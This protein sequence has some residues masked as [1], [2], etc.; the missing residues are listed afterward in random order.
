MSI[1]SKIESGYV[2]FIEKYQQA[3]LFAMGIYFIFKGLIE[4]GPGVQL[5]Q[6]RF[7]LGGG[8][9]AEA[10]YS[11]VAILMGIYLI[12]QHRMVKYKW[13]YGVTRNVVYIAFLLQIWVAF[14]TFTSE[15]PYGMFG[16]LATV[17]AA[18]LASIYVRMGAKRGTE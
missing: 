6:S 13:W 9:T 15:P 4:S 14:T 16:I 1:V 8:E 3:L 5:P 7:F 12:I 17:G 2:H 11:V 10:I 18:L